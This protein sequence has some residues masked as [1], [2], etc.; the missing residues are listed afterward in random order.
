MEMDVVGTLEFAPRLHP[1][2]RRVFVIVGSNESR[3]GRSLPEE[4]GRAAGYRP[5]RNLDQRPSAR[6]RAA[7]YYS[8]A[9]WKPFPAGSRRPLCR[10]SLIL[11]RAAE[12]GR[13]HGFESRGDTTGVTT[14]AWSPWARSGGRPAVPA[15]RT[16]SCTW[17]RNSA[18]NA[19]ADRPKRPPATR[20]KAPEL[21]R[22]RGLRVSRLR[23]SVREIVREL[24]GR[25]PAPWAR[26]GRSFFAATVL[27]RR[28]ETRPGSDH[29]SSADWSN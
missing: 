14:A 24:C 26:V 20:E 1:E 2:I 3:S 4:L 29:R 16:E 5:A 18:P 27:R 10:N 23:A 11:K 21:K 7:D 28:V 6:R 9:A 8:A 19:F 15:A 25:R 17:I 12:A 22:F 13:K